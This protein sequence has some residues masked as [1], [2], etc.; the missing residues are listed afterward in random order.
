MKRCTGWLY[1]VNV[2]SVKLVVHNL[3]VLGTETEKKFSSI[4]SVKCSHNTDLTNRNSAF[5]DTRF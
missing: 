2:M 5:T 3:T 4:C 1:S